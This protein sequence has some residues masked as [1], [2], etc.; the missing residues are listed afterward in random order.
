MFFLPLF[1]DNKTNSTPLISW[2]II[3][4]CVLIFLWQSGL[5]PLTER[6]VIVHYGVV[7]A[8]LF[9]SFDILTIVSSM[10]LHGGFLHL[11]SNMLYLW[12]FG[13]NVEDAMGKFRFI[14]FYLLCGMAAALTQ[15]LIDPSSPIPLIGASGGIAGIL[16][17]YIILY[18]KATI[19]VFMWIFIIIRLLNIPAWIV[20]GFWIG[21]Q[22][23]SVPAAL[24]GGG[25]VAY[26]AHI[27]GF[28]AGM[29]LVGLFKRSDVPLF[30]ASSGALPAWQMQA[31]TNLRHD[32]R[33]SHVLEK[34]HRSGSVP[35]FKRRLKG[36]WDS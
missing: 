20:L 6:S 25:G 23:L 11:G 2:I 29:I 36:P 14:I 15:A 28:I 22:F 7:P 4:L 35:G 5:S 32:F 21:G 9:S 31:S 19:R 24:E 34:Q 27:G 12:I 30:S 3:G 33:K 16:G 1:D 17:G 10:F 26:F 8:R 13:D 18:P